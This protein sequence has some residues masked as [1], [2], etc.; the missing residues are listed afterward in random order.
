L[1]WAF[2]VGAV[3][4]ALC[5]LGEFAAPSAP[6]PISV[7][8]LGRLCHFFEGL[9]WAPNATVLWVLVAGLLLEVILLPLAAVLMSWG[10]ADESFG[11]SY[12]HALRRLW[13]HAGHLAIVVVAVNAMSTRLYRAGERWKTEFESIN[14]VPAYPRGAR[15]GSDAWHKYQEAQRQHRSQW[16]RAAMDRP[17]CLRQQN[18]ACMIFRA[19]LLMWYW[20]AL[21][22]ALGASRPIRSTWSED[23][24]CQTCAY[25]LTGV[26]M[27]GRCPECGQPVRDSLGSGARPGTVWQTRRRDGW[28]SAALKT[29]WAATVRAYRFGRAMRLGGDDPAHRSYLGLCLLPIFLIGAAAI[30]TYELAHYLQTGAPVRSMA[31]DKVSWCGA[32]VEVGFLTMLI[33]L[34]LILSTASAF[35]AFY[36]IWHKR[37]L[38]SGTM[39][40]AA[41]QAGLLV[42][43]IAVVVLSLAAAA[44]RYLGPNVSAWHLVFSELK[45]N[46]P[47]L[48]YLWEILAVGLF[49][50]YFQRVRQTCKGVQ[51]APMHDPRA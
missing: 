50:L 16:Q 45:L 36:W 33:V 26:G 4:L 35:G 27:E 17:W 8:P 38:L 2:L 11:Q 9:D 29:F 21:L 39:Q 48:L 37:N 12:L 10:S 34:V 42:V 22:R 6:W 40:A 23:P 18:S 3:G 1:I 51:Y 7:K 30:P 20:V 24:T 31:P 49:W 47:V 14:P 41:Y 13:L 28:F 25:I 5:Y 46:Q 44:G 15:P 32:Y 43:W 19:I